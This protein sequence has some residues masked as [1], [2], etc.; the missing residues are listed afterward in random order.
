MATDAAIKA[1][2]GFTS[3]AMTRYWPLVLSAL[4]AEGIDTPA[5]RVAAAATLKAEVGGSMGPVSEWSP[6]GVDPRTYFEAKYGASTSVGKRLGNTQPGD[7]Y[8]FRGRGFI[9]LTG[10]SNYGTFGRRIGVDLLA[11][12]DAALDPVIAARVFAA[13]FRDRGV[14]A[15][16][17]A[18]DWREVR[19]RVNGGYNGWDTFYY[20]VQRVAG[21]A[22][23]A[24]TVLA[25][26][27][28][29]PT[30]AMTGLLLLVAGAWW[31]LRR[32]A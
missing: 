1:A 18:G 10:R 15:A 9:Q 5:V 23:G 30:G 2:G 11:N 12:P 28:T 16:A 29:T 26:A 14:A 25:Q 27:A 7:G 31:L 4:Q 6:L 13:Y 19:R 20:V 8:R 21:A 24:V 32:A 17:N 3:T 22:S